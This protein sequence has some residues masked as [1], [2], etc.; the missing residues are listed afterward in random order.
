MIQSY[1]NGTKEIVSK[2]RVDIWVRKEDKQRRW[3]GKRSNLA[4]L[5]DLSVGVL[6]GF[7]LLSKIHLLD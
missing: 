1:L 4:H 6:R 5:P 3:V 2:K 7:I